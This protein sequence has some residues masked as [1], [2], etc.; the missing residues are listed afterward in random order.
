VNRAAFFDRDGVV[1]E[2]VRDPATGF[3]ESPLVPGD[4]VLKPGVAGAL[5]RLRN[6]GYLLIGISNQPAA[7][8]GSV[9][10]EQLRSVQARVEDLLRAEQLEADA[11]RLCFHH[12]EGVIAE[13]ALVCDCRKP[14]PGMLL[15]AASELDIDLTRSWMIGD[16]D[17]D[18]AAGAA[19]GCR[20]VLVEDLASSHKRSGASKPD[21]RAPDLDGAVECILGRIDR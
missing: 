13:L 16:T 7:A 3:S 19:A 1:N 2:L 9:K 20:T 21:A 12:P 8:K 5:K 18:V 15:A 17:S 6:A 10:L 14:A 11:F 4:V